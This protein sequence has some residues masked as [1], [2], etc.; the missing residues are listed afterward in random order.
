MSYGIRPP[1]TVVAGHI[2]RSAERAEAQRERLSGDL[3]HVFGHMTPPI[4]S[5]PDT[6]HD[7]SAEKGRFV[8]SLFTSEAAIIRSSRSE[9]DLQNCKEVLHHKSKISKPQKSYGSQCTDEDDEELL[10]Q[11]IKQEGQE[12]NT[13]EHAQHATSPT[14]TT[15]TKSAYTAP[16]HKS[17]SDSS[18][19]RVDSV[20][21]F[22]GDT[23]SS[24]RAQ[25]PGTTPSDVLT[26]EE[27][28]K[29]AALID[30][31]LEIFE[32]IRRRERMMGP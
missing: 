30:R 3:A 20:Y 22:K 9:K 7:H 29:E 13:A 4:K 26:V 16:S 8:K 10:P 11:Y 27:L 21:G 19:H 17:V 24:C 2:R 23:R 32:E 5:E 31:R 6:E 12:E 18:Y 25:D 14:K 15:I 28:R 1:S